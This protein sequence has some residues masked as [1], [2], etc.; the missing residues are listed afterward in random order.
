ML[1]LTC[2]PE[3]LL[4][5]EGTN[6]FLKNDNP[7]LLQNV[8]SSSW[9]EIRFG[10]KIKIESGDLII[11][12]IRLKSKVLVS[13]SNYLGFGKFEEKFFQIAEDNQFD[14]FQ[15]ACFSGKQYETVKKVVLSKRRAC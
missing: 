3:K 14:E 5:F 10:S 4:V 12:N 2:I 15:C 6:T 8:I 11:I 9:K 7:D 1:R 13:I